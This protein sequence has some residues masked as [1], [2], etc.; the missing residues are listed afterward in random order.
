VRNVVLPS[1]RSTI[2]LMLMLLTMSVVSI[3][4]DVKVAMCV[5]SVRVLMSILVLL[6]VVSVRLVLLIWLLTYEARLEDHKW[7][8]SVSGIFI[9]EHESYWLTYF[10]WK[11]ELLNLM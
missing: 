1:V 8:F 11:I 10:Q 2:V 4:V 9:L 7:S 5:V 3:R 6:N